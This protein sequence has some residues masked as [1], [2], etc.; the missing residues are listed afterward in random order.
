MR[1]VLVGGSGY[2]GSR[3]A[4]RLI[5]DGHEV[6][7]ISRTGSGTASVPGFTYGHMQRLFEG[8]DVVVNLAGANLGTKRWSYQRRKEFITSRIDVTK[9]VVATIGEC[10]HKPALVSMSAAGYYGNTLVPS[11][12]AMAHGNTFLAELCYEWEQE[13]FAARSMTRV[14]V[15]RMGTILDPKQGL[16]RELLLPM[17]LFIGGPLGRGTQFVPWIHHTDAIEALAWL[18]G[19]ADAEGPYNIVA[20]DAVNWNQ[21]S[22]TLGKVMHRPSCI[23]IPEL[24]LRLLV[25]R[26]AEIVVSGQNLIPQRLQNPTFTF[27]YPSLREALLNLLS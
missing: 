24:P 20:P 17:R 1:V 9:Q 16:L 3:L 8:A 12:E 21:F 7:N 5:A 11:N 15:A 27:K 2:I 13:A 6:S 10:T 23:R 4:T 25:G 18:I 26:K 19:S 14:A 22:R